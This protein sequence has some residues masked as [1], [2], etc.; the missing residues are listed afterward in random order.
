[1]RALSPFLQQNNENNTFGETV[2][3]QSKR[4]DQQHEEII[5]LVETM[6]EGFR[7]ITKRFEELRGDMNARFEQVDKRFDEVD[8]R[9]SMMIWAFGIGFTVVL[10]FIGS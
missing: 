10:A 2:G 3:I 7:Q 6:K 4:L 1:L 8:R 9:F 5:S